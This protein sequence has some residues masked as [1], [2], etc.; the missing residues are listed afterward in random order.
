MEKQ[1]KKAGTAGTTGTQ[2]LATILAQFGTQRE[3]SVPLGS[4]G[5][6]QRLQ[7]RHTS[8]VVIMSADG[9]H[10]LRMAGTG[11]IIWVHQRAL[12][13]KAGFSQKV[14]PQSKKVR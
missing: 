12:C 5:H 10:L 2:D 8:G 14:S 4:V 7:G 11:D 13:R 6:W 1:M 3:E 9:W